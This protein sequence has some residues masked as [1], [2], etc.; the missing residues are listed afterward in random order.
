[1]FADLADILVKDLAATAILVDHTGHGKS[2]R[3]DS[4]PLTVFS[5]DVVDTLPSGIDLVIGHSLGGRVLLDAV[6]R[7]APKRAVYLD[8]AWAAAGEPDL[9]DRSNVGQHSDKT[10]FSEAEMAGLVATWGAANVA[11]ARASNAEW[12]G[13][14][15]ESVV[16]AIH[17]TSFPDAAPIVPSLVILADPSPLVSPEQAAALQSAGWAVTVQPGAGHNVHLDDAAA[18]AALIEEWLQA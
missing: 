10:P 2:R 3:A 6:E 17:E 18:T 14:M 11:R 9:S 5:D 12:D 13:S 8:P 1:M 16:S 4:Y 15:F 7:L